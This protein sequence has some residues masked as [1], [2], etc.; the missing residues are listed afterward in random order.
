MYITETDILKG[1]YPEELD[2][3]KRD[4]ADVDQA[5]LEATEEVL[6]YICDR[7]DMTTEFAKTGNARNNR[8]INLVRDIAIYNLFKNSSPNKISDI[9]QN[10][11]KDAVK[12][13]E[14]IQSEKASIPSL[15][16]ITGE[17]S[18][19]SYLA[20]GSNPKRENHY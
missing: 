11:Y 3:I 17:N 18:Q 5:I 8:I 13:L 1:I 7:Y 9:R 20:Y 15:S 16:R 4:G 6:S 2:A 12:A 19:S 10:I 14:R